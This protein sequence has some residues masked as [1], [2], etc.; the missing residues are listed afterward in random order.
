MNPLSDK[1][2]MA[3]MFNPYSPLSESIL[4]Y[5]SRYDEKIPTRFIINTVYH[6]FEYG[7]DRKKFK[8]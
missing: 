2:L 1:L 7:F 3:R 5:Y 8:V 6:F 4:D